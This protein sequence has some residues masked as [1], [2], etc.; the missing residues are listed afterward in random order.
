MEVLQGIDAVLCC[1]PSGAT[2]FHDQKLLIDA[3]I[4]AGVKLFFASEY[5]SNIMSP[6]YQVFPT[7][8][9]GDK[10]KVRKYLEEKGAA[11]QIAWTALNGGP[12]FDM[13]EYQ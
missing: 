7:E 6:H 5:A 4:D 9:V 8:F 3:A 1:V 12:F 2:K 13:C 11:G 10:V